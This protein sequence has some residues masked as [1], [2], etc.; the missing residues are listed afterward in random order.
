MTGIKPEIFE[1]ILEILSYADQK[2][3]RDGRR[4]KLNLSEQLLVAL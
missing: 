3:A 4:N 1:R 2:K